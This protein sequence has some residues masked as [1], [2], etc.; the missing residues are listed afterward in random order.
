MPVDEPRH[1]LFQRWHLL[2]LFATVQLQFG[3][4]RLRPL[5]CA[6]LR[7]LNG[8]FRPLAQLRAV[9]LLHDD[10]HIPP[11]ATMRPDP[12]AHRPDLRDDGVAFWSRES[13]RSRLRIRTRVPKRRTPASGPA[14]PSRTPPSATLEELRRPPR[15]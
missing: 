14:R 7:E 10:V 5:A 2:R 13:S 15:L 11:A 12:H 9:R 1:E 3:V 4:T 8:E 6:R